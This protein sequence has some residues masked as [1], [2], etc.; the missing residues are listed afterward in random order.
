MTHF[1]H[2]LVDDDDPI[3]SWPIPHQ[4]ADALA[5]IMDTHRILPLIVYDENDVFMAPEEMPIN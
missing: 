4:H 2:D 3:T 5:S 1:E